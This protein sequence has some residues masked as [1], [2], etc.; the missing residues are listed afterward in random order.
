[1]AG[2]RVGL[3]RTDGMDKPFRVAAYIELPVVRFTLRLQRPF[4]GALETVGSL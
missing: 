2:C 3:S 1:M 4:S